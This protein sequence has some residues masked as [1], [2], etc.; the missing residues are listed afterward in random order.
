MA[1]KTKQQKIKIPIPKVYNLIERKAI[2][3][4]ILRFIR[5][6]TNKGLDKNNNKFP[7][8]S[9]SYTKSL[10][11]KIAG[12]SAGNV[13]LK[14]SGDMM[15]DLQVLNTKKGEVTIGF[16]KSDKVTN[17]KAE[18]N[19]KGTYGNPTPIDGGK[20]KRDFLGITDSDLSKKVLKKF[21]KENEKRRLSAVITYLIAKQSSE[22]LTE[23][24]VLTLA[25]SRKAFRELQK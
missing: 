2:G 4:E 17:G 19:I 8:Y 6:R 1:Q 23:R 5:N 12:K 11:F 10:D 13:N 21:P 18:G 7:K 25:A 15:A 14:L 3:E 24:E 16:R 20:Y 9:K 22:G